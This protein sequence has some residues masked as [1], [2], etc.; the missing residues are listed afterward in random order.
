M[1]VARSTP[2]IVL[3]LTAATAVLASVAE[4]QLGAHNFQ[5]PDGFTIQQIAGPPLVDRPICAD[6][7]QQGRLYVADSSG[8]ND[9]VEEQLKNPT[10]RIVRLE[11]TDGDGTFDKSTVFADRMMFF[12]FPL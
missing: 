12:C 3:L 5:L 10:H 9:P 8:S 7:D 6:F 11:D 1:N 4:V 2:L